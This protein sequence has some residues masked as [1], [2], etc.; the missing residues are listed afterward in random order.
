MLPVPQRVRPQVG[1]YLLREHPTSI[2]DVHK[3]SGF[4]TPCPQPPLSAVDSQST[5][6]ILFWPTRPGASIIYGWSHTAQETQEGFMKYQTVNK[7]FLKP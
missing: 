6:L 3:V 4:Y 5:Q 7:L 2:I 1:C